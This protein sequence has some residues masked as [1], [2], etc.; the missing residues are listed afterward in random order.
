MSFKNIFNCNSNE[1]RIE[2]KSNIV[3]IIHYYLLSDFQCKMPFL[4]SSKH[5]GTWCDWRKCKNKPP[6]KVIKNIKKQ[7]CPWNEPGLRGCHTDKKIILLAS[8]SPEN[9]PKTSTKA[10]LTNPQPPKCLTTP[11]PKKIPGRFEAKM[12]TKCSCEFFEATPSQ[13]WIYI[14]ENSSWEN[15]NCIFTVFDPKKHGGE[16][17]LHIQKSPTQCHCPWG[18][19]AMAGSH[20]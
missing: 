6:P 10:V 14:N 12:K 13:I 20:V 4:I 11:P 15:K 19:C 5:C 16:T 18:C 2:V 7:T 8:N 9:S 3:L 1:K 17:Q